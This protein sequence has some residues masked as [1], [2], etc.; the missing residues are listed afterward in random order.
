MKMEYL[1]LLVCLYGLYMLLD[2]Y[3]ADER[4]AKQMDAELEFKLIMNGFE[5][6]DGEWIKSPP[7]VARPLPKNVLPFSGPPSGGDSASTT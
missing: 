1:F 7:L 2:R 4:T 6:V 3:M 5:R